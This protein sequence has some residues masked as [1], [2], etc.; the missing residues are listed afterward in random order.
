MTWCR[1]GCSMSLRLC[2]D[3]KQQ[4]PHHT[5]SMALCPPSQAVQ[6]PA[7]HGSLAYLPSRHE[8]TSPCAL[9]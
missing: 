2:G 6:F 5:V 4:T 8:Q 1:S 3:G 9:V 7:K